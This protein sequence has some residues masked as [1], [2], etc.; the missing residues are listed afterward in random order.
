MQ[1]APP[2]LVGFNNNVRYRGMRFH[3]QT[4]DSGCARPHIITHLFADGGRVIKSIRTDYSEYLDHP[5]RAALLQRMMRDQHRAMAIDLRDGHLDK[6]IDSLR[7]QA[8]ES[9][10][11]LSSV[12]P[13]PRAARKASARRS[14]PP[15]AERDEEPAPSSRRGSRKAATKSEPSGAE[16]SKEARRS[17]P[18]ARGRRPS[19][20]PEAM[21]KKGR[22][23]T[24]KGRR[25]L[26]RSAAGTKPSADS[27]FGTAPQ[28]SLDDVI[29]SYVTQGKN[30]PDTR[31]RK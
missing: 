7:S 23:V 21:A 4:E 30:G 6:T 16:A 17:R 10:E 14:V 1:S 22:S 3:I 18:P 31:G 12:E 20:A 11:E 9:S 19:R 15:P 2:P 27:I 5:D 8:P 25:S 13:P 26:V 29:L 24:P 28:E